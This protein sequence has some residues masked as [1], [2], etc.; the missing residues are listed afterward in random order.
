MLLDLASYL[1]PD[2]CHEGVNRAGLVVVGGWIPWPFAV[3]LV[4][5]IVL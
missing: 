2:S 1:I 4:F 5:W 3:S